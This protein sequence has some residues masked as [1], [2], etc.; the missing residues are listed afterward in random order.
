MESSYQ[1]LPP[2]AS[3]AVTPAALP[4]WVAKL[5]AMI[6]VCIYGGMLGLC[7][8]E[9]LDQAASVHAMAV[10]AWSALAVLAGVVLI[11]LRSF[12]KV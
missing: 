6:W 11:V 12:I 1:D 8:A 2:A 10:Q 9:A 4:A 3:S 5:Q 7:L